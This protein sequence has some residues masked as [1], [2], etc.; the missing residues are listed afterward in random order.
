MWNMWN[1]GKEH[2]TK[3]ERIIEVL[4]QEPAWCFQGRTEWPT[5][6][7]RASGLGESKWKSRTEPNHAGLVEHGKNIWVEGNHCRFS[8]LALTLT[9]RSISTSLRFFIFDFPLS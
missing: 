4:R 1:L 2:P 5:V 8:F 9:L 6:A 3:T 7:E